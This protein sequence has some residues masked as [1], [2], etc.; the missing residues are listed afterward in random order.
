MKILFTYLFYDLQNLF[1]SCMWMTYINIAVCLYQGKNIYFLYMLNIIQNLLK[2]YNIFHICVWL[3]QYLHNII[4]Y[5]Y[6]NLYSHI[7]FF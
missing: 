5:I 6:L 4:V 3:I 1:L 2:Y 7:F